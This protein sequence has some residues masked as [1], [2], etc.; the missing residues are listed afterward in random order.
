MLNR[1]NPA[2]FLDKTLDY[3]R[4]FEELRFHEFDCDRLF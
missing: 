2:H 1:G 4:F 3:F